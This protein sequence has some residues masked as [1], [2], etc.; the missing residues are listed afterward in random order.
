MSL[1]ARLDAALAATWPAAQVRD[2][3]PFRLRDGAGG[4]SRVSAA[5][6]EGT[7]DEDALD[8]AIAAMNRP[9]FRVRHGED[10][11][12]AAL[13]ARGLQAF[14]HTVALAA[15]VAALLGPP[16]PPV[17]A[18]T[19]WEPLAIMDEIWAAGGIGPA[20]RAVMDR[21]AGPKTALFGRVRDTA[22]AAGFVAIHDRIAMVHAIE[23][24][25]AFRRLGLGR[26]LMHRAARWADAQGA[27]TMALLVTEA[28]IP[29]RA[30]YARLQMTPVGG[31]HYRKAP[32]ETRP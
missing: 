20:R 31:Y 10:R 32:Q 11:L 4:G 12:D 1:P 2:V 8:A 13:A 22:A 18:W 7:W 15:P 28:N 24:A 21:V 25:P 6:V 30:L 27:E 17:T 29:A 9:L 26:W 19:V 16:L 3:G 23:V 5:T 14:D